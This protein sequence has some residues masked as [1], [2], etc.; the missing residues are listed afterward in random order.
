LAYDGAVVILEA[1][2]FTNRVGDL[3][4][5]DEYRH[6][7]LYLVQSP[8]AGVVIQGTGG[9][10]KLRWAASGRGKRGGARVIYYWRTASD[11]IVMLFI[12]AKSELDDLTATQ[13]QALR[14]MVE[15]EY[16]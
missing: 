9:I 14:K 1:K 11:Q 7:Q 2:A 16:P 13:R 15:S 3:L 6:L 8:A 5:E 4:S 12:Y 10:R